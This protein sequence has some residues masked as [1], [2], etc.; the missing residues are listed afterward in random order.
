MRD[1]PY[2]TR[3]VQMSQTTESPFMTLDIQESVLGLATKTRTGWSPLTAYSIARRAS[4]ELLVVPILRHSRLALLQ[5]KCH[6]MSSLR[7][8]RARQTDPENR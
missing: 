2:E 8:L 1:A 3:L 7:R 4:R 5:G 6:Q